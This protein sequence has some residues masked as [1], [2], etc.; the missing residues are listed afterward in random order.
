MGLGCSKPGISEMD[1]GFE[2]KAPALV[3]VAEELMRK[4]LLEKYLSTEL[5]AD[6]LK[7]LEFQVRWNHI[8]APVILQTS[9][10]GQKRTV[11]LWKWAQTAI[12]RAVTTSWFG[13]AIWDLSP[14]IVEDLV[15]LEDELWKILFKLPRPCGKDV[16]AARA[17]MLR[18]LVEYMHLPLSRLGGQSWAVKTSLVEMRRRRLSDDDMA[19]YL[20]M[21]LWG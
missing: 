5:L 18:C 14:L 13:N 21:M 11:S 7:T 9:R 12:I 6:T 2:E 16:R 1:H 19:S 17:R 8:D 15:C 10:E 4:Q 20:L 3:L